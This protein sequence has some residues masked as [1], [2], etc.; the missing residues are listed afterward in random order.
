MVLGS[1]VVNDILLPELWNTR[2]GLTTV[3]L[4]QRRAGALAWLVAVLFDWWD[5]CIKLT[6]VSYLGSV[7][8]RLPPPRWINSSTTLYFSKNSLETKSCVND[9]ADYK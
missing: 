2:P 1:L 8:I 6:T 9:D 5:D 3:N 7:Y 4:G